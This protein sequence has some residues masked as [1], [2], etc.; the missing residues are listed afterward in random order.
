M[1]DHDGAYKRFFSQPEMV[2][3]LLRLLDK[4]KWITELDFSTL[5]RVNTAFVSEKL[6]QRHSDLIWRVRRQGDPEWLY[7][8]FVVELQ[9]TVNRYMALRMNVYVGLLYQDLIDQGMTTPTGELPPVLALLVYNSRR[10]W[11]APLKA[12][13]LILAGPGVKKSHSLQYIL[14]DVVRMAQEE[15]RGTGNLAMALFRLEAC[16]TLEELKSNL[17]NLIRLPASQD[18]AHLRGI[19]AEWLIQV[20][21]P[22]RFPGLQ[23]NEVRKLT[24]V[25][26]M[27]EETVRDWTLEWKREGIQ[28][29]IREGRLSLLVDLLQIK[30]GPLP[31]KWKSQIAAA[32]SEQLLTWGRRLLTAD[33]LERALR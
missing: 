24:E 20:L 26:T 23:V 21:L 9:S 5:D 19:F 6:Q 28:E 7:I 18:R 4:P 33:S 12:S 25:K 16:R 22:S 13:D 30:F 31:R 1:A 10:G 15:P 14:L 29:G 2:A 27:L 8:Y 11:T 17:D 3:A 32:D